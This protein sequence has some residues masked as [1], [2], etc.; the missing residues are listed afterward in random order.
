MGEIGRLFPSPLPLTMNPSPNPLP[1]RW[2]EGENPPDFGSRIQ[3]AKWFGKFS[4]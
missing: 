1:I 2:G 4:P 3:C